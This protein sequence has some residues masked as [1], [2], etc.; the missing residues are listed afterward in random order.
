[1]KIKKRHIVLATLVLALSAAV[2]VNWQLSDGN[3]MSM[4]P[5]NKELGAV[6]YVNNNL[7]SSLDEAQVNAEIDAK[8][9]NLSKEQ[10]EYFAS[11]RN[12]RQKAQ[13]EVKT[14][15][16]EVLELVD[17]SDEAKEEAVEQLNKLED[18]F[19]S[20]NRVETTLKA[21]GF[22]ECLCVLSKTSCTV[23]VPEN[24][25]SENSA[26]VIKACVD[27]VADLP[28]EKISIVGAE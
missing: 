19:L 20:Q 16:V 8:D 27:E 23:I 3:G 9:S 26:V 17:S 6:T 7:D 28:F 18:I 14:M 24:E 21:K 2:F 25:M 11:C 4:T 5:T 1:M 15:A 10:I 13:D 12:D 22:S